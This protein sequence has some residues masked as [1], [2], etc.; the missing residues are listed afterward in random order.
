MCDVLNGYFVMTNESG[1]TGKKLSKRPKNSEVGEVFCE[2]RLRKFRWEASRWC[3]WKKSSLL[4][5]GKEQ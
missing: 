1:D 2:I 4:A 5:Q 3:H